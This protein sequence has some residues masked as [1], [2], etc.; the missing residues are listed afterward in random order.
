[1]QPCGLLK[2]NY[3]GTINRSHGFQHISMP[4]GKFHHKQFKVKEQ[5]TVNSLR[6]RYNQAHKTEKRFM[7]AQQSF[8]FVVWS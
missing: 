1:M 2:A 8:A 7:T 3:L 5:I 6:L 4:K